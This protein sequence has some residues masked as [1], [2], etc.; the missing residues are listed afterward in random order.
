[1]TTK[2][3]KKEDKEFFKKLGEKVKKIILKEKGY[4]SLD[5]FS[6]EFHDEIA[7]P[8]LYQLCDGQRD[9]KVSTLLGLCRALE[10]EV[11]ELLDI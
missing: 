3:I 9:M 8:T 6:L 2:E 1:M 7:K 10:L 5:A 11:T 4:R